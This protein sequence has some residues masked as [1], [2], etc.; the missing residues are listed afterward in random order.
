MKTKRSKV[1]CPNCGSSFITDKGE[2][3]TSAKCKKCFLIFPVEKDNGGLFLKRY[4]DVTALV[5]DKKTGQPLWLDSKGKKIRH[6][7]PEVR[8]DL[9]HDPLGWRA[10]GKKVTDPNY[11]KIK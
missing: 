1:V 10:T 3:F 8:Y 11:G 5:F 4:K 9:Y 2:W 7:N 6:D